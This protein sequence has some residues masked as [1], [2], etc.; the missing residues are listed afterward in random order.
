[1]GCYHALLTKLCDQNG[2]RYAED[3]TTSLP[4]V[5]WEEGRVAT[6]SQTYAV[7]SPLVIMLRPKIAP[8]VPILV[9]R[10]PNRTIC[11]IPGP[12]RPMMPNGIRI[13]SPVFPQCPGQTDARTY[14]RTDRPTDRQRKSLTTIGRCAPRATRPN[15]GNVCGT[16]LT[17]PLLRECPAAPSCR[18][19]SN[20]LTL[21]LGPLYEDIRWK[22]KRVNF[23]LLTFYGCYRLY[24]H[25]P[26][27][28]VK[29]LI[30][31]RSTDRR[32][33]CTTNPQQSITNRN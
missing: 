13:R 28:L 1:M 2:S 5:I 9:D 6:L 23:E 3:V 31:Y 7:K 29:N 4:K 21:T 14:A 32:R 16:V 27:Y 8:N 33:W 26:Q 12:V 22:T 25:H 24:T 15:N 10:S 17:A 30:I 18:R 20:Q 11:L 19:P